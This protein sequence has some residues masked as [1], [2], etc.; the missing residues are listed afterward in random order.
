MKARHLQLSPLHF[1]TPMFTYFSLL[2]PG[3]KANPYSSDPPHKYVHFLTST[4]SNS[5]FLFSFPR[6][7]LVTSP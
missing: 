4:P 3:I 2:L 7:S 6:S 5:L 1:D